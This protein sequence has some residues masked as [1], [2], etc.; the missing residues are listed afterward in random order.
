[1]DVDAGR[2]G[3][4]AMSAD[5]EPSQTMPSIFNMT[6]SLCVLHD[7]TFKPGSTKGYEFEI[8]SPHYIKYIFMGLEENGERMYSQCSGA[9]VSCHCHRL[10]VLLFVCIL[11]C[12]LV[13]LLACLLV[14]LLVCLFVCLHT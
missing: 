1:M 8:S 11:D 6:P 13:G 3:E 9:N 14:R 12:L 5:T 7:T 2:T 10:R 4:Q